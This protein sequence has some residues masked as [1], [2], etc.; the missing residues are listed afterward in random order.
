[1]SV[2]PVVRSLY[3]EIIRQFVAYEGSKQIINIDKSHLVVH[4]NIAKIQD[5]IQIIHEKNGTDR[6]GYIFI[7]LNFIVS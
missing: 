6:K 3:A 1:M 7:L 4:E 5:F 2:D